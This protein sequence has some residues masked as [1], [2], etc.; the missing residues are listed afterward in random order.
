MSFETSLARRVV[1]NVSAA[2]SRVRGSP[3]G[4]RTLHAW[5]G[6]ARL[7]LLMV[8]F[9]MAASALAPLARATGDATIWTDKADYHPEEVVTIFGS[10]FAGDSA[11][12]VSVTRPN[13]QVDSWT[14]TSNL[15]GD[16]ETSY[17]LDGIVGVY[18][19]D[20]TDGVSTATTTFTD[21]PAI[22]LDQCANG[23]L[24]NYNVKCGTGTPDA[25]HPALPNDGNVCTFT[26]ASGTTPAHINDIANSRRMAAWVE[27]G[28]F[29]WG[30]MDANV[31]QSG[32]SS[33]N[34]QRQFGF[35]FTLSGCSGQ[36]CKVLFAWSGH[37]AAGVAASD[38][39]WGTGNGAAAISGAPFHMSIVDLDGGGGSQDRSVQIS[40]LI[41]SALIVIKHVIN[42]NGGTAL[43]SDF[44]IAVTATNPVP[45]SFPG[46]E[47]P[48]TAVSV[49]AGSYSV[50][51]TGPS[52]YTS[53]FSSGCSGTI[54]QGETKTCTVTNDDNGATLIVIKHVVNNNGGTA[55]A[56]DFT[57]TVTGGS[58]SP[59]W[60]PGA[61]SPGTTVSLNAGAYVVSESGPAGYS[62]SY[63]ADC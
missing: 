10:G 41:P 54:A 4:L 51:E 36:G 53:S 31:V 15:T 43:A 13:G 25:T 59:G 24:A 12:S 20:A 56:S 57:M 3:V 7:A 42:N 16:F 62:A 49:S 23:S 60:F 37:I 11:V 33:G 58:P 44:T 35:S 27:G 47:S 45:S 19:V 9:A 34:S 32:L 39:G 61:E 5:S 46:A 63:S 40:A 30:A 52:E 2:E 17:Q 26:G 38:G 28:T 48:G 22:N 50:S 55:V 8:V 14:T 21:A 6:P 29:A 18:V 1:R